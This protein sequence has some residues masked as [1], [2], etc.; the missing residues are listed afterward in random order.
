LNVTSGAQVLVFVGRWSSQKGIDIIAD[1]APRLLH[2]YP[3]TQI[4]AI[5]PIVDLL[6]QFALLKFQRL[7]Q[8]YPGRVCA[9]TQFIPIPLFMQTGADFVLIPSRDEPFGL[10]QLE[11]GRKGALCIGPLIGGLGE[12]PGW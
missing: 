6:G 11:F 2:D 8:L 5:G 10:I 1:V 3:D 9:R 4:I 12:M 7:M